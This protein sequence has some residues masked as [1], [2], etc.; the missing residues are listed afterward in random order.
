MATEGVELCEDLWKS[1]PILL[2]AKVED[3]RVDL[4]V[5][6]LESVRKVSLVNDDLFCLAGPPEDEPEEEE[7]LEPEEE[8]EKQEPHDCRDVD[9]FERCKCEDTSPKRGIWDKLV[10]NQTGT[11][12]L[13]RLKSSDPPEAL[14]V[15]E[16]EVCKHA[17]T[18]YT[19]CLCGKLLVYSNNIVKIDM[20]C[21][22]GTGVAVCFSKKK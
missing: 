21:E 22:C 12:L 2:P 10:T 8:T 18:M 1:T 4:E 16:N 9:V 13:G 6:G 20:T 3:P 5:D 17:S 19:K 7:K 15:A 11:D 14:P